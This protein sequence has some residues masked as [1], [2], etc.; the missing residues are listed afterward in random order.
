MNVCACAR[1][2][3]YVHVMVLLLWVVG[4]ACVPVFVRVFAHVCGRVHV[5]VRVCVGVRVC[6]RVLAACVS[7]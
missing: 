6:A 3:A 1:V 7:A 4:R 5:H 2:H